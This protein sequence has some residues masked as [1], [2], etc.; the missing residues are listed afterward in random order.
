MPNAMLVVSMVTMMRFKPASAANA[1]PTIIPRSINV[2]SKSVLMKNLR[3]MGPT[4]SCLSVS[5]KFF[6]G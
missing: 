6:I 5:R 3:I 1:D 2:E 4:L